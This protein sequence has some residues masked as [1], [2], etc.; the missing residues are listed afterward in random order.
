[1]DTE[2]IAFAYLAEVIA[3]TSG[4][5]AADLTPDTDLLAMGLD[6]LMFVQIGRVIEKD[7]GL[8]IPIRSFYD[9]L[10]S[11]RQLANKLAACPTRTGYA[12][13]VHNTAP[14]PPTADGPP[15]VTTTISGD[16]S[17]DNSVDKVMM[18]HIELMQQFFAHTGPAATPATAATPAAPV[19]KAK[20]VTDNATEE[21][22]R[23]ATEM[24][25]RFTGVDPNPR[26]DLTK[27]QH[28]FIQALIQRLWQRCPASKQWTEEFRPWLADWKFFVQVRR[29][30]KAMRFPLL[31]AKSA[32]SYVWDMDGN[33]YIDLAMGM[34]AHFFGHSPTFIDDAIRSQMLQSS[35]IGWQ[36]PLAGSVARK[37]CQLTGF[38]RAAFFVTGSD[39]V[40]LAMRL[41]RAARGR[42][43][44]VQFAG[45]YHGICS[46]MLGGQSERGTI[47]MS[48][49]IPEAFVQDILILDYG[50][51]EALD[52]IKQ[53]ANELAG[54]FVEPVQGR[55]VSLQPQ[56]FLRQLRKVTADSGIPLVFD[57]MVN[58]FRIAPGGAQEWFGVHADVAVYGKIIGGGLPLSVIAGKAELMRWID[59]GVWNFDDDSFPC[60]DN[61]S[62]GG[63]HN[64]HPL[65][66]AAANAVLDHI[67]AV[68]AELYPALRERIRRMADSLNVFFEKENVPIQFSH[69]GTQFRFD[70]QSF[71]F[72][73]ELFYHLLLER[74]IFTW[75]L[76]G[77]NLSTAHSDADCQEI[78]AAV[79]DAV[80]TLRQG[81]F[82]FAS[83]NQRRFFFPMSSVQR[84]IYSLTKRKDAEMPYHLSGIWELTGEIDRDKIEDCLHQVICRHESLRTSFVVVDGEFYQHIIS[85]P[86]FHLETLPPSQ[87]PP[88]DIL[89]R[90]V[91]PFD[92]AE[93]PLLR[94]GL[95]KTS[96]HEHLLFLDMHHLAVDGLSI[97][98][99]IN[100]FLQLYDDQALPAVKLQARHLQQR[101]DDYLLSEQAQTDEV[102]WRHILPESP[103]SLPRLELPLDH[104]RPEVQDFHGERLVLRLPEPA[105]LAFRHYARRHKSSG[106]AVMLA[107][108]TAWLHRLTGQN[109]LLLGL[110]ASGRIGVDSETAVGM[111]VNTV[112]LREKIQPGT[113][114]ATLRDD[115]RERLFALQEHSN[116][117]FGELLQRLNI[118]PATDRAPLIDTMFSYENAG[119]RELRCQGFQ[120][121]IIEQFEGAGMFDILFDVIETD[122]D[123]IVNFSYPKQLLEATTAQR[124]L[125]EFHHLFSQIINQEDSGDALPIASPTIPQPRQAIKKVPVTAAMATEAL[126]GAAEALLATC[127][128]ILRNPGLSLADH[129][130]KQGGDSI[131]AIL[132]ISRLFDHG[133]L[134]EVNEIFQHP[135][136]DELS[137]KLTRADAVP[138]VGC[139]SPSQVTSEPAAAVVGLSPLQSWYREK[140]EK[141][142]EAYLQLAWLS[143][144]SDVT[145]AALEAIIAHWFEAHPALATGLREDGQALPLGKKAFQVTQ[146]PAKTHESTIVHTTRGLLSL[147]AGPL[148]V[149][150]IQPRKKGQTRL[151]VAL[152]HWIADAM[153]WQILLREWTMLWTDSK[154]ARPLT[155]LPPETASFAQYAGAI[156][157][158]RA[159]VKAEAEKPF[160]REML[161][162]TRHQK[163]LSAAA[164]TENTVGRA[165]LLLPPEL[166]DHLFGPA[167]DR[168][169]TRSDE[170]LLAAVVKALAVWT[171]DKTIGLLREN[172]GRI[173]SEFTGQLDLSNTPGWLTS[174]YPLCFHLPSPTPDCDVTV[175]AVRD[176][177]RRV[178]DQG[179]GFGILR[180]LGHDEELSRLPLPPFAFNYLGQFDR[181]TTVHHAFALLPDPVAEEQD[182]ARGFVSPIEF[183]AFRDNGGLHLTVTAATLPAAQDVAQALL[184]HTAAAI[185]EI[186][187]EPAPTSPQDDRPAQAWRLPEGRRLLPGLGLTP[188]DIEDCWP[189][190]PMQ[191]GLFFQARLQPDSPAYFEQFSFLLDDVDPN[192]L[193]E[194]FQLLFQSYPTLRATFHS[195]PGDGTP[196][197]LIHRNLSLPVTRIQVPSGCRP[198]SDE[199]QLEELARKDRATGFDVTTG[200]LM[201]VAL[202]ECGKGSTG[203]VWSHHHLLMDGWCVELLYRDLLTICDTLKKG[204]K[205]AP[206]A[207]PGLLPYFDWLDKQP[208]T[209]AKDFWRDLLKGFAGPSRL[210]PWPQQSDEQRLYS[211]AE[212]TAILEPADTARVRDWAAANAATLF[213]ALKTA[214]AVL[215]ARFADTDDVVFGTIVSG[216][217][218]FVRDIDT[219]IGLLINTIPVRF[220]LNDDITAEQALRQLQKQA[221]DSRPF[222]FLQL[223]D[224]QDACRI[225][226]LYDHLLVLENYPMSEELRQGEDGGTAGRP[227]MR[228]LHSFEQPHYPLSLIAEPSGEQLRFRFMFNQNVYSQAQI[229][230]L[231]AHLLLLLRELPTAHDQPLS[232]LNL[233]TEDERQWLCDWN[234]RKAD[235]PRQA[236]LIDL[237]EKQAAQTPQAVA[238]TCTH[239]PDVTYAQLMDAIG[240]VATG[241]RSMPGY[242]PKSR[243]ALWLSKSS[244]MVIAMLATLKADCA[245]VPLDP[246]YPQERLQFI[247]SDC[248]APF[249]IIGDDMP[250]LPADIAMQRLATLQETKTADLRMPQPLPDD[251][252]YVIYTSGS[253]GIP[254]GCMVS[255][256]N[257][258][259]LLKNSRM[260]FEFSSRD[261]WSNVHSFCF[262]FSVWE[263]YGALLYGGR[264][265]IP[266][267]EEI[268][269]MF[270]LYDLLVREK[271]TVFN[272][273]PPAFYRFSEVA[274]IKGMDKLQSIKTII[275]GGDRL[276]PEL[277]QPW[278]AAVPL[279]HTRLVNMYGI[280]ETTVHVSCHEMTAAEI[281][282][283]R[284]LSPIGHPIPETEIWIVD[285]F[286]NLQPPGIAGEMWIAG[287]GV[288]LG[289][290]NRPE[291][292]A[293]RFGRHP[294]RPDERVY[295]SG[296]L[297]RIDP[298]SKQATYLGRNDFQV[299]V[300]GFRVEVGEIENCL[301]QASAV[302][303]AIVLP[304]AVD[305]S[306][307]L[308]AYLTG[309]AEE[310]PKDW[311]DFC[312]A[313]L[314]HYMIPA[315]FLFVPEIPL[316]A[317]GKIDRRALPSPWEQAVET[318]SDPLP[319]TPVRQKLRRLWETVLGGVAFGAT[320]SF[321][322]AGGNS[323][324]AVK[325]SALVQSELGLALSVRDIFD[326][327]RFDKQGD[328]LEAQAPSA[329]SADIEDLLAN[330]SPEELTEA[331]KHLQG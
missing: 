211:A 34:G 142:G 130:F 29:D 155:K 217:P 181:E 243:L 68:S 224:I 309:R 214:W 285:R 117:P 98:V 81:G 65:A 328:F 78:V 28:K 30:T 152:H 86:R 239:R 111:F 148:L 263:M 124:W 1:M 94:V 267:V 201:R 56:R 112:I 51:D 232:R 115:V 171:G 16:K 199:E 219:T 151:L 63:T 317:N 64:R 120:G 23:A 291:L 52:V 250:P 210:P 189:L 314:P 229:A 88:L 150:A 169:G 4:I 197:Q 49:G 108:Y 139:S 185:R 236:N 188:V 206:A 287:T 246:M 193:A 95:M 202:L 166:A 37:I 35:A 59:G 311:H 6:S 253:T 321:F 93:P 14:K 258:V 43:L 125:E 252:A 259:R 242:A 25:L 92:L 322:T 110:P 116:L 153:T 36:A 205:N 282:N 177:A 133:W 41:V 121:K 209:L 58:G 168:F 162:A 27:A 146:Y 12:A 327:P 3:K 129:Y 11:V 261:V 101:L 257:V 241:I 32:G 149:V 325:L 228:A 235:Y 296:D 178:N 262:D 298:E 276:T 244:D 154:N 161:Q 66:L 307:Q 234:D 275:F 194:A 70:S 123:I 264:L 156:N 114:F 143:A 119:R 331:L 55:K 134:L 5:P 223:S 39:A 72:E 144:P 83:P 179:L 195:L 226:E 26:S 40:M 165:E 216:R 302:D 218:P 204:E 136:L 182:A 254:K 76:H 107:L 286:G 174:A 99:I 187:A 225:P 45:A 164:N 326:T 42:S 54:V 67:E 180:Y 90:F 131:Q 127:R 71:P 277:L 278:L 192:C 237:L 167:H 22:R 118:P 24:R 15:P 44:V 97:N 320:D 230:H 158:R 306:T 173:P 103:D 126:P 329:A 38:D 215:L 293:K 159:L 281:A 227:K 245:Y 147:T 160:W 220:Q 221:N 184:D 17:Q 100:E 304:F 292:N 50:S 198:G 248:G 249:A 208:R 319:L 269:D 109:D 18:A 91:K 61:I 77:C 20:S 196:V 62:T 122:G 175:K 256:R 312:A 290:L 323:L 138:S 260:E 265:V 270:A 233:L 141:P 238:I 273:V 284:G 300:R 60:T 308:V 190:T 172:H 85:E 266:A 247:L 297:G 305:G 176:T 157:S 10:H 89:S 315:K 96:N 222:E 113:S 251:C 191:D 186:L 87:D 288:C 74:G 294:L 137:R 289:Y 163:M 19:A 82:A 145:V 48:P 255:H 170:L 272:Q 13:A 280:T 295:H 46:D 279:Q 106:F 207:R 330:Y 135:I 303:K 84:R 140:G 301:R 104:P 200:P 7:Y 213:N 316:T 73:M 132:I 183:L 203:V 31:A 240:R 2:R 69:F 9:D 231:A 299:Q 33:R 324:R 102:F 47:P 268:R 8:A 310:A 313:K 318:T 271:V 21:E 80:Q 79:K 57:E 128:S 53:R 283:S 212:H 274:K 75:E 105:L